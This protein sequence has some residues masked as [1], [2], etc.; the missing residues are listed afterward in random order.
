MG[1]IKKQRKNISIGWRFS[2][3]GKRIE[4]LVVSDLKQYGEG[5][6]VSFVDNKMDKR[7]NQW[8]CLQIA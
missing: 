1:K 5:W 6:M 3:G 2:R 4:W 7:T 8:I